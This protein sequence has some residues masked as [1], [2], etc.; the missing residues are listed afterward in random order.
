MKRTQK[1]DILETGILQLSARP[2]RHANRKRRRNVR[3]A[4]RY[5]QHSGWTDDIA[6]QRSPTQDDYYTRRLSRSVSTTS[7][8]MASPVL[9][10]VDLPSS[11]P[12]DRSSSISHNA[13]AGPSRR[14]SA[15]KSHREVVASP[16]IHGTVSPYRHASVQERWI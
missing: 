15:P 10:H 16:P 1:D 7:M 12:L 2:A 8:T 9:N 11:K 13:V 3:P 14:I 4:I 6:K 5:R